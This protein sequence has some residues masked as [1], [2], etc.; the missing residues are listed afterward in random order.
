[1]IFHTKYP[2]NVRASLRS[3]QFFKVRPPPPLTWNPGSAPVMCSELTGVRYIQ[4]KLTRISYIGTFIQSSIYTRFCSI[5]GPVYT[6]FKYN[7]CKSTE[8]YFT[9]RCS[10]LKWQALWICSWVEYIYYS[11]HYKRIALLLTFSPVKGCD[12]SL[13]WKWFHCKE[14]NRQNPADDTEWEL[15]NYI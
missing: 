4:V 14:R 9:L 6:C 13:G 10:W 1:M 3:A 11:F 5:Q 12:P 8:I 7:Y 15:R 2:K